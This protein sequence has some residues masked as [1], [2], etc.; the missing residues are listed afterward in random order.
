[1]KKLTKKYGHSLL[2]V[3]DDIC[4]VERSTIAYA[5]KYSIQSLL[6]QDGILIDPKSGFEYS[7]K[8]RSNF[9]G[10][11]LIRRILGLGR[12]LPDLTAYGASNCDTFAVWGEGTRRMMI[13]FGIWP[14]KIVI[15]GSPR[16]DKWIKMRQQRAPDLPDRSKCKI[17]FTSLIL[18]TI[19]FGTD[20]EDRHVMG[21]LDALA[22]K[23]PSLD[24]IVRPH[25]SEKTASYR[26]LFSE[27]NIKRLRIDRE[28]SLQKVLL[29]CD[30]I[31]TYVSTVAVEGMILG[32]PVI[33]LPIEKSQT[34]IFSVEGAAVF[35]EELEKLQYWINALLHDDDI[36]RE[37][38]AKRRE[39]LEKHV[40][41]LDGKSS[42]RAARLIE[43]S[44]RIG[45]A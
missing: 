41:I 6:I 38:K 43:R 37:Y 17:L 15:V 18:S 16:M 5:R 36:I 14:E 2:V 20:D 35:L 44:L 22:E 29:E 40:G 19:K 25:P 9:L 32:K 26:R 21:I 3:G 13:D 45:E 39:F 23:D 10:R 34:P 30:L 27:M 11:R 31:L 8:R 42:H 12:I 24:I 33:C 7:E 4:P 1:L 28:S